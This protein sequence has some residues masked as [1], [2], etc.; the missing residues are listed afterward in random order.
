MRNWS[1]LIAN[2]EK[3]LVAW[4]DDQTRDNIPL[5]QSLL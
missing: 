2:V 4:I 5:S 3:A 1:S